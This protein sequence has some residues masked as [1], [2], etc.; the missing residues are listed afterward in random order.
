MTGATPSTELFAAIGGRLIRHGKRPGFD[1]GA[2]VEAVR[3][4]DAAAIQAAMRYV[5]GE[6]RAVLA[7]WRP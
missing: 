2:L 6:N 4:Y 7:P 3:A 1:P 5:L